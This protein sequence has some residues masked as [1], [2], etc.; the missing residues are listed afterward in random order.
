MGISTQRAT[1]VTWNRITGEEFHNFITWKD[2]RA[3]SLVK[4]WNKS[5]S[6][7][8]SQYTETTRF[9]THVCFFLKPWLFCIFNRAFALGQASY[10]S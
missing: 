8:V 7:R 9:F 2:V 1:F 4:E 10:T 6:M 3:E 5:L